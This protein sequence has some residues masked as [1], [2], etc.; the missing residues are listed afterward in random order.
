[1]AS[2]NIIGKT[3]VPQKYINYVGIDTDTADITIDNR[4]HTFQVDVKK[5]PYELTFSLN[6]LGTET[7]TYSGEEPVEIDLSPVIINDEQ[8]EDYDDSSLRKIYRKPNGDNFISTPYIIVKEVKEPVSAYVDVT[9]AHKKN[10]D[11]I[12]ANIVLDCFDD[13]LHSFIGDVSATNLFCNVYTQP[14]EDGAE[15]SAAEVITLNA[16]RLGSNNNLGSL[17][18]NLNYNVSSIVIQASKYFSNTGSVD[19]SAQLFV[20]GIEVEITEELKEYQVDFPSKTSVIVFENR[21][22]SDTRGGRVF[23]NY[24]S[25]GE[26]GTAFSEKPLADGND[27]VDLHSNQDIGGWKTFIGY[28]VFNMGASIKS[29][30]SDSGINVSDATYITGPVEFRSDDFSIRSRDDFSKTYYRLNQD[31]IL[32]ANIISR[33]KYTYSEEEDKTY[34]DFPADI[35]PEQI[36][37]NSWGTLFFNYK[38]GIVV[39]EN[40]DTQFTILTNGYVR[41]SID[42]EHSSDDLHFY[43]LVYSRGSDCGELD[44]S[45]L[46]FNNGTS[47]FKHAI[48]LDLEA[49]GF[50]QYLEFELI[51]STPDEFDSSSFVAFIQNNPDK[52]KY[53]VGHYSNALTQTYADY[54]AFIESAV[55]QQDGFSINFMAQTERYTKYF[56]SNCEIEDTVVEL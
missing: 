36:G 40:G 9:L 19:N 42:G 16:L 38:D 54:V 35:V 27:V 33:L 5:V 45:K 44:Y 30:G 20:N 29:E 7:A 46:Y 34:I 11:A 41:L 23:I 47:L 28:A 17:T 37:E 31:G 51:T 4:E 56:N 8:F 48:K 32:V 25:S 52:L 12:P 50:D 18:L 3:N 13:D 2:G 53:V 43:N 26:G 6:T 10:N 21:R 55:S 22:G 14:D 24:I 1:M 39:D 15:E 49:S